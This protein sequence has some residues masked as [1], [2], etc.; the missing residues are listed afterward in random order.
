MRI[1]A[2]LNLS[3]GTISQQLTA[4]KGCQRLVIKE[5]RTETEKP[6]SAWL[7]RDCC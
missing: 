3:E 7:C 2:A 6:G 4:A 1:L 5:M